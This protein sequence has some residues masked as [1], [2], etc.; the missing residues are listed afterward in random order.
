M[1]F[2]GRALTL[3][4]IRRNTDR[5]GRS[6]QH[7]PTVEIP[8]GRRWK[9]ERQGTDLFE[10]KRIKK[11]LEAWIVVPQSSHPAYRQSF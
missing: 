9:R 4:E 3:M 5:A 8:D 7:T 10:E 2:R 11:G 1:T 6:L